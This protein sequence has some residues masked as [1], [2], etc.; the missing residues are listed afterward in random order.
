MNLVSLLVR[1][2]GLGLSELVRE[3]VVLGLL[4]GHLLLHGGDVVGVRRAAGARDEFLLRV[5]QVEHERVRASEDEAEEQRKAREVDVALRIELFRVVVGLVAQVVVALVVVAEVRLLRHLDHALE[6]IDKEDRHKDERDPDTVVDAAHDL[7]RGEEAEELAPRRERQRHNQHHEHGH[8]QHKE[9]KH[10]RVVQ[11][12]GG[13]G[14]RSLAD[15]TGSHGGATVHHVIQRPRSLRSGQVGPW[16]RARLVPPHERPIARD[17]TSCEQDPAEP[18][19]PA[20]EARLLRDGRGCVVPTPRVAG[21]PEQPAV[22]RVP[23]LP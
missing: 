5:D 23:R 14:R 19:Q 1:H 11:R 16:R 8:L 18:R 22:A 13:R 6:R 4:L 9:R 21:R 15:A 2:G 3:A 17:C 10:D 7:A 20:A 12:H